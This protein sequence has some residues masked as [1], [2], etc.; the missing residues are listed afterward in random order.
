M[1]FQ[2]LPQDESS[3]GKLLTGAAKGFAEQ[4]PK[5][6]ENYR[7]SKSLNNLSQQSNNLTPLQFASK[8]FGSYG[9]TPQMV[10]TLGELAKH[11]NIR[12]A[13]RG[14]KTREDRNNQNATQ[15]IQDFRDIQFANNQIPARQNRN[16]SNDT[17]PQDYPDM[18]DQSLDLQ[19]AEYKN[20]LSEEFQ[21]RGKYSPEQ[22]EDAID[23][24]FESGKATT[25]PEALAIAR[26]E[27]EA[28]MAQPETAQK[29]QDRRRT[30]DQQTDDLFDKNLETLLQKKG[31]ETYKDAT[32]E[33]QLNL[34]KLARNA[35][36]TGQMN[37]RQ[38]AEH[39]SKKAL[40]LAKAKGEVNQ[41]AK[42]DVFDRLSTAK[43]EETLK[44]LMSL[45]KIF[46]ESGSS[47]E[48]YNLLGVDNKD[49]GLGLSPGAR[50]IIAYPRSER[51]KNLIKS[52]K[53]FGTLFQY[54]TGNKD[55]ADTKTRAFAQELMNVLTPKDSILAI[56]RQMK[57][58]EPNFDETSFFD[59]LRENQ[60]SLGLT[61]RLKLEITKGVSDFFP[62]WRDIGLF[63]AFKKPVTND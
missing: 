5:E 10:A 37:Q 18:I 23:R 24:A 59:Y 16:I 27:E 48:F 22:L 63:P 12:N 62:N 35:V 41:I 30:I 50:A 2:I 11:Q 25:F 54:A 45:S 46:A 61:P 33:F 49:G 9:I 40:N 26:A 56:A 1:S 13:Y 34:K 38:A 14:Q 55:N 44:R 7:L 51:V 52:Q 43:K 42:R 28:Y 32:G 60:D 39:F 21:T 36:A 20:P 3:F 6:M 19:G 57:Q 15:N 53:P 58:Q 4:A 8:A 31:D 29:E 47:E 17:V